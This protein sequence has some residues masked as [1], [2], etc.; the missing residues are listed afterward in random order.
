MATNGKCYS[1]CPDTWLT[2]EVRGSEYRDDIAAE[3]A[4]YS[5]SWQW[6]EA[7]DHAG[8]GGVRCSYEG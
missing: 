2:R 8:H 3:T 5:K 6:R 4:V 1:L 7:P